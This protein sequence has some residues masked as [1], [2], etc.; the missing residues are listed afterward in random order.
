MMISFSFTTQERKV[1]KKKREEGGR[2]RDILCNW[3]GKSVL[4]SI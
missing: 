4:F 1:E 2:S 3:K